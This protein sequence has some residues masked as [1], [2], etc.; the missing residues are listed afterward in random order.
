[1]GLLDRIDVAYYEGD[2]AE[3]ASRELN[4]VVGVQSAFEVL[5]V[6]DPFALVMGDSKSDLRVMQWAAEHDAGISAAPEHSST[7]VLEHVWNTDNLQFD[8]GAAGDVLR[9]VWAMNRLA[10]LENA[11]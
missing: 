9:T 10:E 4:K 8:R 1:M 7:R 5:G 3:I 2:A 11:R 6:D